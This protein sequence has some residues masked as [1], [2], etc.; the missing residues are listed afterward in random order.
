[1]SK[2]ENTN[3]ITIDV[4]GDIS[5]VD[6]TVTN[7]ESVWDAV[8]T[9]DIDKII[10]HHYTQTITDGNQIYTLSPQEFVHHMPPI[11][12]INDM[13]EEYPALKQAWDNFRTMYE[14]V[15]QDW[16]DNNKR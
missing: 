16:K 6:T 8:D 4:I 9:V 3:P 15:H 1:M 7:W 14:M 2:D 13:C 11:E 12:K 5:I 10:N